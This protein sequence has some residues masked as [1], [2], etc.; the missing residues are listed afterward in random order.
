MME[1]P[2]TDW[3]RAPWTDRQARALAPVPANW[4]RL[5]GVVR[6]TFTH[7][8]L[9]LAV[10]AGKAGASSG[11]EG[12]P[13][14]SIWCSVEQFPDHPLPTLMKKVAAHALKYLHKM[15]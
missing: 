13:E 9:E 3:R 6:H 11:G 10:L 12:P 15:E 5:P 2:S 14:G 1:F 4:R 8:H 7:F